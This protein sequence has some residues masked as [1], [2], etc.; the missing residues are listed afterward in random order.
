M[1]VTHHS[2]ISTLRSKNQIFS[3]LYALSAGVAD[4]ET[5]KKRFNSLPLPLTTDA[6]HICQKRQAR[7]EK[8][9]RNLDLTTFSKVLDPFVTRNLEVI[10]VLLRKRE[11]RGIGWSFSRHSYNMC[12]TRDVSIFNRALRRVPISNQ[13]RFK[14]TKDGKP[15]KILF[16]I[17]WRT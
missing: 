5:P 17:A 9:I 6:S 8:P 13:L 7:C 11:L 16:S 1:K 4:R 12:C 2:D 3:L 14:E 10:K 15:L